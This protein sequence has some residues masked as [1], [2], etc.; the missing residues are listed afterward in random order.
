MYLN[1]KKHILSNYIL[2]IAGLRILIT[3]MTAGFRTVLN[4]QQISLTPD[5]LEE[6]FWV[7][8][9]IMSAGNIIL[10]ALIFFIFRKKIRHYMEI[11]PKQDQKEIELKN[12]VSSLSIKT[13]NRLIKLWAAIFIGTEIIY[14]FSSLMY[15]RFTLVMFATVFANPEISGD[16]FS[17]IYNM[18]HGFKYLEVLIALIFGIAATGIFLNDF[19]LEVLPVIVITV[20]FI[21]FAVFQM[22]TITFMGREIDIVW[23]SVIYHIV[24]TIGLFG[25]SIYLA[26]KYRGL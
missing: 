17:L 23:T 11:I 22:Q 7:F 12:S 18:T 14:S 10:T 26:K 25:L 21:A 5:M 20:F 19:L 2:S 16:S 15:R 6:S 8:Q 3:L 13:L 24:E 9:N 1:K 4:R